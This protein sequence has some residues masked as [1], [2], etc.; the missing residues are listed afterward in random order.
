MS[1]SWENSIFVFLPNKPGTEKSTRLLKQVSENC[2][3]GKIWLVIFIY[4]GHKTLFNH[5]MCDSNT[6]IV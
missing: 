4:I 5:E 3:I 6:N 1:L 2:I